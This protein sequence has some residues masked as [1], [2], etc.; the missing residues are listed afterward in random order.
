MLYVLH[1]AFDR[2]EQIMCKRPFLC[3]PLS[4]HTIGHVAVEFYIC[5]ATRVDEPRVICIMKYFALQ[6][7]SAVV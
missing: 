7:C 2:H 1:I 5:L 6:K 4:C 3:H